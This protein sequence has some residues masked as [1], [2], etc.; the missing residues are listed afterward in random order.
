MDGLLQ[1]KDRL[2]DLIFVDLIMPLK[3]GEECLVEIR[4]RPKFSEVPVVIYST[5]LDIPKAEKLREEGA[6][7]YLRKPSSFDQLK[8]AL[9][10]CIRFVDETANDS[11][12]MADF[13][14]QF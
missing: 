6:N 3:D 14:I 4:S 12:G 13:I 8:I 9:T 5:A 1:S 11:R 7:L 2:P 10:Q